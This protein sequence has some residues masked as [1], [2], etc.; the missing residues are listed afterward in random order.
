MKRKPKKSEDSEKLDLSRIRMVPLR[1]IRPHPLN[2]K[3][4]N[5]IRPGDPD[6]QHLAESMKQHGFF[7][8]E[9]LVL[10]SDFYL[11]SG[12][13]RRVAAGVAGLKEVPGHIE[14]F[15][16]KHPYV[17]AILTAYNRQRIKTADQILREEV[18]NADPED[19]YHT[20]ME[21]RRKRSKLEGVETI[22]LG[23]RR[24]RSKISKARIPFLNAVIAIL[25][26]Y[27]DYWPFTVRQ[28]HY[29][30]LNDPPL[31]HSGKPEKVM[32]KRKGRMV[33]VS[34]R[35]VND[36]ESYKAVKALLT[37]ARLEK[38]I[39]FHCIHDP[40]R[41]VELWNRP[42]SIQPF[43]HQE[44]DVFLKGY[45]RDLMQSQPNHVEIVGEK[46]TVHSILAPVAEEYG[47]PLISGRGYANLE[48]RHKMAQRYRASGKEKLV[49]LVVSDFDPEGE[50][51]AESFAKSMRDDFGIWNIVAVKVALTYEQ[52]QEMD[53]ATDVFTNPKPKSPRTR[54][55]VATYGEE[56]SV[57]EL[58]SLTPPV[59]Q[60]LLRKGIESVLDVKAFNAEVDREK[61]DAAYLDG[62]RKTVHRMLSDLPD[63]NAGDSPPEE[64]T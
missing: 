35:Y 46:L 56:T 27:S 37:Q 10:T 14:D 58:E 36:F 49:L 33:E 19:A 40:T 20:L 13:R 38:Y 62:V 24:K 45:Q 22:Y 5:S 26:E 48:V 28:M 8:A 11:L 63:F 3:I 39:P 31:I 2:E 47:I 6:I 4:Y 21:H 53:L 32:R 18:I 60:G 43:L 57:F 1:D 12:H 42:Q 59:L 44:I 54:K 55:F 9:A 52:T 7:L 61:E 50:D 16:H 41:P 64:Q 23:E 15:D 34:N 17:P 29:Y 25:N 51:I 30:L